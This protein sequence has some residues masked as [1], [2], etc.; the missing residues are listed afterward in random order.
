MKLTPL[1]FVSLCLLLCADAALA[2]V[3][4]SCPTLHQG[5]GP[6][7]Y[8]TQ[9]DKLAIVE[10]AHF[11]PE[12]RNLQE[13]RSGSLMGDL[14]YTLRAFP[15]HHLALMSVS[16]YSR[17]PEY[18]KDGFF[19]GRPYSAECYFQRAERFA[20]RDPNVQL[21]YAIHLHRVGQLKAAAQRYQSALK[22]APNNVE[23]HYNYGLLLVDTKD[24]TNAKQHANAA[25][26]RGYPLPGLRNRLKQL[27]AW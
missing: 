25:Y 12:V 2:A 11:T 23:A 1:I 22:L 5:Y 3:N 16:R 21:T 10:G 4:Y 9:K 13:G 18:E 26:G 8:V 19:R 7:D 14:D 17:M 20:P 27:G 15:N 6:Y 24:F